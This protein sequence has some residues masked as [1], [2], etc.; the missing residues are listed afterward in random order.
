MATAR[1]TRAIHFAFLIAGAALLVE[2]VRA[3]GLER[4]V[5]E[6]RGFGGALGGVIALELLLD[7]CNTLG[8][9][10]TL[11]PARVD[12][13]QLYW[14]RQAG[15]AVNQLTPTASFGGEVVKAMLLRP[16]L[17][18]GDATASIIAA[19]LS[20]AIAQ[21]LLVV[22]GLTA[23]LSLLPGASSLRAALLI[24]TVA[25]CVGVG[26]FFLLQR[27]GALS[28]LFAVPAWLGIR[29]EWLDRV[30][31]RVA[32]VDTRLAALH[33]QHAGA[34][35]A[36][37]AWHFVAQLV[38]TFQLWYIL[39]VLG[40][41]A[42][43]V[44]C[45][46]IEAFALV[47]DSTLFFVPARVGVQE[48]SRVLVFTALGMDAATGLAVAVIVRA[49]QLVVAALGLLAYGYFSIARVPTPGSLSD[50]S[51]SAASS[52]REPGALSPP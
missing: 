1:L 50:A 49:N 4:L 51:V 8:W 7:A 9:R 52:G 22:L 32:S 17:A 15:T 39:H 5:G 3:I 10:K 47:I 14:I 25:T 19:K 43:F 38:S 35:A 41:Q 16:R 42:D 45:V 36:S 6:L 34:F 26:G 24:A 48:A 37:I 33:R 29:G 30:R 21:T 46:A 23:I 40:V 28:R 18:D 12:F 2:L 13:W 44:T 20:F 11:A 31:S 27:R